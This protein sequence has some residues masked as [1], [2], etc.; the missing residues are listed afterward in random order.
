MRHGSAA[1]FALHSACFAR[2]WEGCRV[3]VRRIEEKQANISGASKMKNKSIW[4]ISEKM[5]DAALKRKKSKACG[6]RL[7][8]KEEKR[9]KPWRAMAKAGRRR[10]PAMASAWQANVQRNE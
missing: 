1:L 3:S 10:R 5:E 8:E 4:N 2:I 6:V 7:S 9:R